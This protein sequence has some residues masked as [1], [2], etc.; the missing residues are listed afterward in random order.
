M[1]DLSLEDTSVNV[2]SII[3]S[4]SPT[5]IG[6]NS[7]QDVNLSESP[8]SKS[9]SPTVLGKKNRTTI[10]T[11]NIS[12]EGNNY[13]MKRNTPDVKHRNNRINCNLNIQ[14]SIILLIIILLASSPKKGD[15]KISAWG[16]TNSLLQVLKNIFLNFKM[17]KFKFQH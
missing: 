16:S 17:Q 2:S 6:N 5:V 15:T 1:N 9:K 7:K 8:N 4:N 13:I 3:K 14:N 11:E 12:Y 10:L